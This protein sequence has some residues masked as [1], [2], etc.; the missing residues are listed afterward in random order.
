MDPKSLFP[1]I[2][3]VPIES[4]LAHEGVVAK[5]VDGI[6]YNI[7]DTGVLKNPIIVTRRDPY[8]VVIDGMHR[9]AACRE[10]K[11]KDILVCEIDYAAPEIAVEGWNAFAFD[12]V[13]VEELGRELIR[14]AVGESG[15]AYRLH[16]VR[17]LSACH[18]AA[19]SRQALI[20]IADK[21]GRW[22]TL[23]RT[24][25]GAPTLDE[26]IELTAKVDKILERRG[27]RIAYVGSSI[28]ETEFARTEASAVVVRPIFTKDEIIS[29][30][31][32]KKLFPR[33][34][35][36]HVVP[37]RPLRMDLNL[38]LLRADIDLATKNQVLQEHLKWCYES[39]RVRY[40]PEPVLIFSD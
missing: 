12:G 20:G 6:I 34:S 11:L 31:L 40:Y 15:S 1:T 19:A 30:T 37:N 38:A 29:R 14:P 4:C 18:A 22:V 7:Q 24:A 10:L 5:W 33:K 35:T 2:K 21:E 28:S 16:A 3:I 25:K 9:F 17:N 23:Q 39:D 8:Y 26:L 27:V 32:Q 13:N 36:K